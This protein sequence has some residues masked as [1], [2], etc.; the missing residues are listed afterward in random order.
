MDLR[1]LQIFIQVYQEK[2]ITKAAKKLLMAQPAVSLA[3][4]E[5]ESHYQVSLFDRMKFLSICN[6]YY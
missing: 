4:K 1:H 6:S 3:I 2:S 5:L